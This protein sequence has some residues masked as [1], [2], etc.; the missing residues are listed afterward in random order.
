MKSDAIAAVGIALVDLP[1]AV[2]PH[3]LFGIRR[4]E[5]ESRAG[6]PLARLAVAQVNPIRF[7]CGNYSKRAAVALPGSL[8]RP[9][10]W[11]L[12][13]ASAC[14]GGSGDN[15]HETL[16]QFAL[17]VEDRLTDLIH[18]PYAFGVIGI[19]NEAAREHLVA[20]SSR[21]EEVDGLPSRDTVPGR[22]DVERNDIARNGIG[23]LANRVPGV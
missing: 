7:T 2:E 6:A 12:C 14:P 17:I 16:V 11:L 8:H 22:R 15:A 20:I 18:R 1:I 13:P 9:S 5:M 21:V 23:S 10:P 3:P 19:I 4:T